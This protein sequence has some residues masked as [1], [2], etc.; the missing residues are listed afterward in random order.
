MKVALVGATGN[1]GSRILAELSRRG[2]EVTAIVR[3]PDKVPA[4]ANVTARK[5]DVSDEGLV[6]ELLAGHDVAVSAVRFAQSDPHKL[7]G[8]PA[9]R[10]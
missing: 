4:E 2:H 8:P 7:I 1:A 5:G 3:N 10:G 6:S 9:A